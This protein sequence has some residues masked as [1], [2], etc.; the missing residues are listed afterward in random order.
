MA[1]GDNTYQNTKVQLPQGGDRLSI[2]DDG[3]FDLFGNTVTGL[4]IKNALYD[5]LAVSKIA[6]GAVSTALS[7]LNQ[8]KNTKY[9]IISM[10]STC[11]SA[12]FWLTS[13]I[14]G[15][16]AHIIVRSGS[17]ASGAVYL[18]TSGCSLVGWR[19]N[20]LSGLTLNNSVASTPAIHLV[21]FTTGEWSVVGIRGNVVE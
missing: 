18:S 6:T 9:I 20:A 21:C 14:A 8:P 17:T 12:L 1:K 13:C 7:V 4:Q 15:E 11:I 16:E 3:F 2:D 5:R 10:T 19:G